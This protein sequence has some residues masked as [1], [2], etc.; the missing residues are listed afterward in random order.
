MYV[1]KKLKQLAKQEILNFRSEVEIWN[2][3][4]L[5]KEAEVMK[6]KLVFLASYKY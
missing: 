4:R 5:I 1:S 3:L 2:K 6:L